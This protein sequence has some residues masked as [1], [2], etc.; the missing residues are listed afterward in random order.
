MSILMP[1]LTPILVVVDASVDNYQDL[2]AGVASEATVL[3]LDPS[4]D[5]IEQIAQAISAS[6]ATSVHIVSHGSPGCLSLGN[7][8]LNRETLERYASE[9]Q[10]W[11]VSSLLVYGCNVA[12]GDAGAEFIAKLRQLTGA[13]IA[14]STTLVGN[15]ELGGNWDLDASTSPMA[16]ELA[17]EAATL[18]AYV[19]V[20]TAVPTTTLGFA[21]DPLIGEDFTF[22]VTFE[23][24]GN[25][26]DAG[27]GPFVNLILD[28]TGA[29]GAGVET[30]DG[31]TFN[32]A[33]VFGAPVTSFEVVFNAGG[34]AEHP[35]AVD[36]N[37]DPIVLNA[38]AF[39]AE[40]GDTLVVLQLPFS[41]I[42]PGQP[43]AEIEVS[44]NISNLADASTSLNIVAQGGFQFG[45]DATDN[46]TT[47]PSILGASE[48]GSVSP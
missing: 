4:R 7:S 33:T 3:V 47:D 26:G 46:P 8:Q 42:V 23:N 19:G 44:A 6:T 13:E 28:T 15:A 1:A 48:P 38:A 31:I 43:P 11:Q 37:G 36:T 29:D 9:L 32:G 22:T 40:P 39:G 17:F 20:L 30:D 25:P 12:A 5:G 35:L 45:N 27:F 34:T 2:I 10:T 24:T 14:A 18:A 16:K 21:G 41:S